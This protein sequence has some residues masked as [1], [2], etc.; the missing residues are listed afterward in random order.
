M[1]TD[2]SLQPQLFLKR[3]NINVATSVLKA[4]LAIPFSFFLL[5]FLNFSFHPDDIE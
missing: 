3:S 1:S 5:N 2:K 4:G